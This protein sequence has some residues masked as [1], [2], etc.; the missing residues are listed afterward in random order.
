[1]IGWAFA[2]EI[3]M[4]WIGRVDKTIVDVFRW[5]LLGIAGAGL[6]WLPAAFQ[7]AHGWTRLHAAMIAGAL[8]LGAPSLLWTIK[9]WGTAGATAVW[10][11][12]GVSDV[13]LGLWLMHKRL[14]SGEFVLWYRTVVLPPLLC[15]LPIVGLSCWLIPS[16][17]K[18]W[19]IVA[20][21]GITSLLVIVSSIT[22]IN[23]EKLN[24][25]NVFRHVK[26]L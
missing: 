22:I 8:G 10:V 24:M 14:L 15:S 1:M 3:F 11:L 25:G 6:M 20:W 9:Y 12:H 5:L 26:N 2:T 4:A 7:Q 19:S 18:T 23:I 17:L 21:L 13:T 16:G